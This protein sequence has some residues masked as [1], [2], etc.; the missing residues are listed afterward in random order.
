MYSVNIAFRRR[1]R[2]SILIAFVEN[3][4]LSEGE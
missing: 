4:F 3:S 2:W 1:A